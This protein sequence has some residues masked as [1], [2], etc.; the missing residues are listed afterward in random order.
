MIKTEPHVQAKPYVGLALGMVIPLLL[1]L[2]DWPFRRML[3]PSNILLV[4]LLGVFFI[5]L[6]F[7]LWPSICASLFSAGAF[8]YFFAPPIFSFAIADQENLVGLAVMLIVGAFT[9]KQAEN[10]RTQAL[11]AKYRERRAS[12]LYY[13]SKE[14]AEARLE[15]EII[16]IG[17]RHIYAEF[18]TRNTILFPGQHGRVC[19]PVKPAFAISLRGANLEVA[20]W[21]FRHQKIAGHHSAHYPDA[22]AIYWP[23][24]GSAG[25]VG[26]L[27]MEP[28]SRQRLF[29]VEQHQL[30]ETFVNQ[31]IHTLE[32][33]RLAEQ[34]KEA[35][36][37]MQ[38]ETL[39][40]SLLS[41]ISHD[42]RTPLA[43]IVGAAS[44][45]AVDEERLSIDSRRNLVHV[46]HE[47]AHRM[48]DLTTKI[49]EMAR[50]E[51]G[52]I[53]LN[54]QWY[55][56][57]ELVGSALRRLD[58]KLKQRLINVQIATSQALIFVDAVLLQQ[59]MVNL[60]DN[61]DKYSP[62]DQ[63][64]DVSVNT[65]SSSVLISIAD[66]GLGIPVGFEQRI[67]DKFFQI[68]AESAQSGVGLGLSIC[69]AIVEAHGG[70][71]LVINRSG[72]G[73][74]F[75]LQLPLLECP[76]TIDPEV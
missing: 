5:A 9:S 36:L 11:V 20:S 52:E 41:S 16:A 65:A 57:E 42:L 3:T 54:R 69:R 37:K 66:R 25:C 21:V 60:L 38:S 2:V 6:R 53:Q 29:L 12:A 51:A 44:T 55:E 74:V 24:N 45:L 48:S 46:I 67:F 43:T 19:Y 17:V 40:N 15:H 59:V 73:S 56:P 34:A 10:V 63:A 72:G 26:V 31:V 32:R 27:V 49:L 28:I 33:A 62:V 64:I 75:Q 68:H 58:K 30:L 22:E 76:P 47:E 8:A 35:T 71:I 39:R 1:T 50:L 14:L 70:E 13:L 7:G 61:A 23:M 18:N 4:Y